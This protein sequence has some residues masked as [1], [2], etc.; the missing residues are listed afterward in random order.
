MTGVDVRVTSPSALRAAAEVVL[1][2]G[3]SG[4]FVSSTASVTA[5]LAGSPASD[6]AT[7]SISCSPIAATGTSSANAPASTVC[8]RTSSPPTRA[9]TSLRRDR[10]PVTRVFPASSAAPNAGDSIVI[11]V[12]LAS[13]DSRS[14]TVTA[15]PSRF[16]WRNDSWSGENAVP[17]T[18]TSDTV[19]GKGEASSPS[20]VWKSPI[21]VCTLRS[22]IVDRYSTISE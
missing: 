17:A 19:P 21:V 16:A 7:S 10:V 5:A 11:V 6:A 9:V 18:C 15:S 2:V 4:A 8:V 20:P 1:S 12:A 13:R 22:P 14:E 3:C